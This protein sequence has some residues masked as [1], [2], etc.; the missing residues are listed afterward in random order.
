MAENSRLQDIRRSISLVLF[1]TLTIA[2]LE[3]SIMHF[4]PLISAELPNIPEA[5][6]D[7]FILSISL[8]PIL[9]LI[10]SNKSFDS[11]IIGDDVRQK[12]YLASGIPLLIAIGLLV[13]AIDSRQAEVEKLEDATPIYVVNANTKKLLENINQEL[14]AVGAFVYASNNAITAMAFNETRRNTDEALKRWLNSLDAFHHGRAQDFSRSYPNKL[15]EIRNLTL[16]SSSW[17]IIADKYE[18]LSLAILNEVSE[19]KDMPQFS[20]IVRAQRQLAELQKIQVLNHTFTAIIKTEP[21]RQVNSA[22]DT[23]AK[24]LRQLKPL[25]MKGI[26][27]EDILLE[28]LLSSFDTRQL[29]KFNEAFS[30]HA[31]IEIQRLQNQHVLRR[32]ETLIAKLRGLMGFNG[33]IHQFKNYVLRGSPQY[34][35]AFRTQY[36]Q[37]IE[38]INLLEEAEYSNKEYFR[39]LENTRDVLDNYYQKLDVVK[40]LHDNN[41]LIIDIDRAVRIDDTPANN[42]LSFLQG[43]VWEFSLPKVL[44]SLKQ[45]HDIISTLIESLEQDMTMKIE[46]SLSETQGSVYSFSAI[47]FVLLVVVIILVILVGKDISQA[48]SSKLQAYEQAAKANSMK[49]IFLAN[50]SHEIRTP[51]NG[52]YGTLQI[53]SNSNQTKEHKLLLSKA[54]LSAKS[55]MTIINDILDFS[56]IEANKL[57]LENVEFKVDEIAQLVLS[58]LNPVAIGKDIRLRLEHESN[59][60]DGWVGD[61]TRIHQIILNLT[62]NAVKFTKEGQVTLT[63]GNVINHY[64]ENL[65]LKVTDTGIGMS[66][67]VTQKIFDRF[68]QADKSTTREYGGTGL[69]MAITKSLIDLM[70]GSVKVA[71]KPNGGTTFDILL[72]LEKVE[73]NCNTENAAT[74]AVAP[75]NLSGKHVLLAEDNE[76]NQLI[77]ESMLEATKVRLDIVSNG[78]EAVAYVEQEKPDLILMD[79]QMPVMSGEE[80]CEKIKVQYPSI[81]VIALTANVMDHDVKRYYDKGFDGHIAKPM[82]MFN[83]YESLAKF[84]VSDTEHHR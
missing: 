40:Q 41:A 80:A 73:I 12:I 11:K 17:A 18:S 52:V 74:D 60:T 15:R 20:D 55:L 75:P 10:T 72:P 30:H 9:F 57:M 44:P 39:Q 64:G 69:G 31:I 67:E 63:V 48:Y 70:K 26:E 32:N 34:A 79:I 2:V 24:E 27:H 5:Y 53:L 42:A 59:F 56:K 19:I 28:S 83:L 8:A 23:S 82:N 62:S 45:K 4:L 68:E 25:I 29:D 78:K 33:L 49:D 43:Y 21:Y 16:G 37:S 58:D 66:P 77:V 76:I 46:E 81:P 1:L 84:M 38:V 50:M 65:H 3:Y 47:A 13:L 71:S 51:I 54:L 6:I 36:Q 22:S 14:Y 35:K 7:A 61:P